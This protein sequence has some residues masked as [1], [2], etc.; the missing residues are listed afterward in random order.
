LSGWL[1]QE[2]VL[3]L[4]GFGDV[5]LAG[6]LDWESGDGPVFLRRL[7]DGQVWRVNIAMTAR[8]A[9]P[10]EASSRWD[11]PSS[12]PVLAAPSGQAPRHCQAPETG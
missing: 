2:G 8:K 6:E 3:T 9:T 4:L 10:A 11:R 5:E 7:E 1:E 12:P